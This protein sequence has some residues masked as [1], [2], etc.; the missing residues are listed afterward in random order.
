MAARW[1]GHFFFAGQNQ[2]GNFA[3][4][5]WCQILNKEGHTMFQE[6]LLESSSRA[7]RRKRWPMATAFLLEI[8]VAAA[9]VAVPLLGAKI[10][11]VLADGRYHGPTPPVP[12]ANK[13]PKPSPS[14]TGSGPSS[15]RQAVVSLLSCSGPNCITIGKPRAQQIDSE[16]PPNLRPGGSD[17][18]IDLMDKTAGR[19]P[20]GPGTRRVRFSDPSEA[21]LVKR[22]EPVYPHIAVITG[23]SGVVKLHAII[24]KD[25]S[26]QSLNVI[27]G[28]PLLV[29][30]AVEAVEQWR[31]RP[32]RLNGEAVE[33]E[34][35][36]TVNF[37]REK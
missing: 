18:V 9:L 35:F 27:A 2:A 24:A 5:A 25:G 14:G 11:P 1:S 32:Y 8:A 21:Q 22:V 30:A 12:L 15:S 16:E 26:I 13:P 20:G 29:R 3:G 36:I 37:K 34:T 19:K 33:V 17:T 28:H 23:V 6:T 4:E 31:Y 7:R 10:V